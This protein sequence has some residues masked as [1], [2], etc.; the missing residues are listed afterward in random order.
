VSLPVWKT[1]ALALPIKPQKTRRA[2]SDRACNGT[3]ILCLS[4]QKHAAPSPTPPALP[5]GQHS[6]GSGLVP[7]EIGHPD[8]RACGTSRN[9]REISFL[10]IVRHD[11]NRGEAKDRLAIAPG[12]NVD[13]IAGW[14][15]QRRP[16]AGAIPGPAPDPPPPPPHIPPCP[17]PPGGCSSDRTSPPDRRQANAETTQPRS[18]PQSGRNARHRAIDRPRRNGDP[19]PRWFLRAEPKEA[20]APGGAAEC[21]GG[22]SDG[23]PGNSTPSFKLESA[24]QPMKRRVIPCPHHRNHRPRG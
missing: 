22:W 3:R 1:R 19:A 16:F 14:Q 15:Q 8:R 13:R 23:Q 10:W 20:L 9:G 18:P 11:A 7:R 4:R 6:S 12:S 24:K 2:V 21:C 5:P 17:R